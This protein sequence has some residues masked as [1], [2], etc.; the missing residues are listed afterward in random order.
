MKEQI[1]NSQEQLDFVRF[2]DVTK[3][4]GQDQYSS[5]FLNPNPKLHEDGTPYFP[6]IRIQGDPNNYHDLK[7]H[8][9]DVNSFIKQWFDYK[10]EAN[11]MFANRNLEEFLPDNK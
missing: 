3:K 2:G 10:K 11:Y 8:K 1:K 7:I 9:D 4:L 5:W 6:E